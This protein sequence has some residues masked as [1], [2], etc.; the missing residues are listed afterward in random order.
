VIELATIDRCSAPGASAM[1]TLKALVALADSCVVSTQEA[2]ASP[3]GR[4]AIPL[5]RRPPS[6][7]L[8]VAA[9][10]DNA[11][12]RRLFQTARFVLVYRPLA[13]VTAA[14]HRVAVEGV[15]RMGGDG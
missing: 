10:V 2:P 5:E 12:A 4:A 13:E 7:L 8:V 1:A 6:S 9:V 14:C 3:N 11:Q 15:M